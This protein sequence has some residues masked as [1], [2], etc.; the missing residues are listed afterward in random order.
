MIPVNSDP[1]IDRPLNEQGILI[2]AE[3]SC[4]VCAH[5]QRKEIEDHYTK[6]GRIVSRTARKFGI[7]EEVAGKHLP[8]HLPSILRKQKAA[9]LAR[10]PGAVLRLRVRERSTVLW[11]YLQKAGAVQDFDN[12]AKL[13]EVVRR[14]DEMSLKLHQAPG[15]RQLQPRAGSKTQNLINAPGAKFE[16]TQNPDEPAELAEPAPESPVS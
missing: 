2:P 7:V 11:A 10:D 1:P 13:A 12:V 9:E 3:Q 4:F 6:R 15:F 16:L 5:P 8:H 14:Y